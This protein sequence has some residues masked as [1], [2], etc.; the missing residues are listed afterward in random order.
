MAVLVLLIAQWSLWRAAEETSLDDARQ[1]MARLAASI[2]ATVDG[3]KHVELH[4]A[5][6]LDSPIYDQA[7]APLRAILKSTPDVRYIYTAVADGPTVRFVLDAAE[8]GDHDGDGRE[9]RAQVWEPYL[10]AEP[11]IW[12]ALGDGSHPGHPVA[13]PAPYSDEWGTFITGYAPIIAPDGHQIGIVG[14]DMLAER[15]LAEQASRR[16][17]AYL[18]L[19]PGI[20]LSG[21][22]GVGAFLLRRRQLRGRRDLEASRLGAVASARRLAESEV[23]TRAV[24]DTALDAV[25]SMDDRG[26]VTDWNSQAEAT[27][28]WERSEAIGRAMH[29]LIVPPEL[30]ERHRHG[31]ERYMKT[32]VGSVLGKR[33]EVPALRK[34]RSRILVELAITPVQSPTG[35]TFAAFLR[36]ISERKAEDSARAA[37][38]ELSSRL[39]AAST[40]SEAARAANDALAALTGVERSAVLLFDEED[41]CR[42]VGWRG[43]S[44]AYR[45][46]IDGHCPWTRG[47][48]GA[49]PIV[50][51]DVSRDPAMAAYQ[52]AFEAEGI[53]TLAFVPVI[54]D[55]GV[56]GKLMLY[57]RV[58][59]A[60]TPERI[61]RA[62]IASSG[63]AG[64]V[65][66]LQAQE[67]LRAAEQRMRT[68]VESAEAIVAEYDPA[69]DRFTFVSPQAERLGYD[70]A[71]WS[72][73]G[74]WHA[75]MHP[76]DRDRAMAFSAERIAARADHRFQCRLIRAD[77]SVVWVEHIVSVRTA[78]SG[79][80]RLLLM[81]LDITASKDAERAIAESERRFRVIADASP[82]LV[83]TSDAT[84]AC[85]YFNAEWSKLTGLDVDQLRNGGW[86]ES[87]HPTERDA[88]VAAYTEAFAT[89][90]I[91]RA[92]YR[93]RRADGSYAWVLDTGRANIG[94]D[95]T[96]HGYV[97]MAVDVSDRRAAEQSV[98]QKAAELAVL[99]A[100]NEELA[101]AVEASADC[102]I[103]TDPAG[104]I[105][106]VNRAFERL[107]GW[108]RAEIA[109]QLP[110]VLRS[111]RQPKD[112][113]DEVVATLR[114]GKPWSGRLCN[115]RRVLG[116]DGSP[117]A[118]D[119]CYWV[120]TTITPM[121]GEGGVCQGHV[122]VQRDIT[123]LV[124]RERLE[125][126][127]RAGAEAKVA[128]MHA[129]QTEAPFND[130]L[131]SALGAVMVLEAKGASD[132]SRGCLYL[133]EPEGTSVRL[134][135]TCCGRGPRVVH[136]PD[137]GHLRT[138][139]DAFVGR[140]SLSSGEPEMIERCTCPTC[141]GCTGSRSPHGHFAVPLR[142]AATTVGA[143]LLRT[144]PDARLE[145][146]HVAALRAI[147]EIIGAA[148][149]RERARQLLVE[150]RTSAEAASRAKSEFLANMSHEIR[151]PLT[152]ILGYA[153]LL[154]EDGDLSRAPERRKETIATIRRA[155]EHLLTIV[156]DILDLSKIEAGRMEME[157]VEFEP[158]AVLASVES[159][160]GARAEE[161]GVRLTLSTG[162]ALPER[163]LGDPTRLRQ[164]LLN[165]AGN[166]VKFT[167]EGGV[168][169]SASVVPQPAP[170]PGRGLGDAAPERAVLEVLFEDSGLGMSAEQADRLFRPFSQADA[171]VTRRQG[172]TGLGLTISRRLARLMGG[173]VTLDWTEP[174]KGSRF[175]LRLPLDVPAGARWLE[176]L[177]A[178]QRSATDSKVRAAIRIGGRVL[179]AED[180]IDNQRL[181]SFHLRSAGAT[182]DIAENGLVALSMLV[183]ARAEGHPY[184]L[185]VSDMQMPELDGY[186]LARRLRE[187]GDPIAIVALTAH[188]MSDDR[189]RCIDAGCDDY[190]T[191]PI[192][193][194]ALLATCRAWLGR[195]HGE[196]RRDAA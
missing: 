191:K 160:V 193:R 5:A 139:R 94:D 23:R 28:G 111:D 25:V 8:P 166:A 105:R 122:S 168:R 14:V 67:A 120:E 172:G 163:A 143:I 65:A 15:F 59:G 69:D 98:A 9:D 1:S 40:I 164:I 179:L 81:M 30:A 121:Y 127:D 129:L 195:R 33:I 64:S 156:N 150:A 132:E 72:R 125:A 29:D 136:D 110:S 61:A 89:R 146:P 113:D 175:R 102:V 82:G 192:D 19:L 188:A 112:V 106:Y 126:I 54:G 177:G 176:G 86:T 17:A 43:I 16:S 78:E 100:R 10:D 20:A 18:G 90:T 99:A 118:G 88:I 147:G 50:V 91:F 116:L 174:G 104:R 135:A 27:F 123:E 124:E 21:G 154:Q 187:Q 115:R 63:L 178:N 60:L 184:D 3:A 92:E 162:T 142:G 70:L 7:I 87:I 138:P 141:L 74:F 35:V 34:D 56:V 144:T 68:I 153:D 173:D 107:S 53:A 51:R 140:S 85:T 190:A 189:A 95:G 109:E 55:A 180:G 161:K 80:T 137:D 152:A 13:S 157:S 52:S 26:V 42:F 31:L 183:Q 46:R 171:S 41:R 182:V 169:I 133:V 159:L 73:A 131:A 84:A 4:D 114:Q 151:T 75:R 36:D 49:E 155:G 170:G 32:G 196:G 77:G 62:C 6:L 57:D 119:G 79:A 194:Q 149:D 93:L 66:R 165:L 38:L 128:V 76:E 24:I 12:E 117:V 186:S 96:F 97:G 39:A 45:E 44:L 48:L 58:P 83:W 37:A 2:A 22:I 185:L 108:T 148:I 47:Q 71:E 103:I 101:A 158:Q 167:E 130:R 134:V 11:V 145:A 181:I